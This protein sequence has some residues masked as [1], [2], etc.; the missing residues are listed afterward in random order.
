MHVI[1]YVTQC[2]YRLVAGVKDTLKYEDHVHCFTRGLLLS[3]PSSM[4]RLVV[5]EVASHLQK[6]TLTAPEGQRVE[7]H[8]PTYST[9]SGVLCF[10]TQLGSVTGCLATRDVLCS[11]TLV[12]ARL[13][14]QLAPHWDVA[15]KYMSPLHIQMC[16]GEYLHANGRLTTMLTLKAGHHY[17]LTAQVVEEW[18][19]TVDIIIGNDFL[20]S[21]GCEEV[22]KKTSEPCWILGLGSKSIFT[23][24]SCESSFHHGPA[25]ATFTTSCTAPLSSVSTGV[26]GVYMYQMYFGCGFA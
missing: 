11:H 26:L 12:S 3:V 13:A 15:G 21:L 25:R 20:T 23:F 17:S 5:D 1:K 22:V 9:Q 24:L 18:P 6:A 7:V 14:C 16:N 19:F 2:F 4:F 10:S 8:E